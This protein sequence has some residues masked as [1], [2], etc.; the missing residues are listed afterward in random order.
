[1]MKYLYFIILLAFFACNRGHNLDNLIDAN[2]I[3]QDILILASDSLEGRAPMTVGEQRTLAYLTH[4]MKEIGLEPAFGDSYLQEVPLA[5]ITSMV[6]D[7]IVISSGK[8]NLELI[9]GEN[10]T[11]WSPLLNSNFALRNSELIFAGFGIVAPEYG[12][13]DFDGIDLAGKTVVVLVNDPG[14]HTGNNDLFNANAMTFYGRWPYKFDAANLSGAAGCIIIHEDKAAGYPWSVVDRSGNNTEYYLNNESLR[15][16]TCGVNGWITRETAT[17]LFE[18]CGMDYEQMKSRATEPGFK[19]VTMNAN[20]SVS[21]ENSWKESLSYNVGGIIRGSQLPDEALV[22]TAHWDHLGKGVPIDGDSIYN[23]ASDNAAAIAWMLSIAK[24]F[25]LLEKAPQ[26]SILFL[27]PTAE[28]SGLIGSNH[29]VNNSIFEHSKT[30]ACFN[31]DVILF[32]GKFLDVTVTGLGHSELDRYLEEE[33]AKQ[34]RYICNDPNPENGM[35]FRSDQ[36]PFL[37]AGIPALFAKGYTHQVDMG[38]EETLKAVEE[39]WRV[40]YHK[41]SDHYVPQKHNLDG[42][43]G[44]TKLFFRLGNRLANENYFPKWSKTSEFYVE[45]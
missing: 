2:Q 19:P 17:Q 33:A 11:L 37:R 29:Y 13:N 22:Y 9:E 24:G 31:S 6:Q 16:N 44:D 39:Y 8:K 1:M 34:G 7:R 12:W 23:G 38:K 41:P 10:Y 20:Y 36:L 32:L 15:Q 18:L 43:V 42:L 3:E 28:E 5:E 35:F 30:V 25:K 4:R 45:R 26:R 21:I 27:S 40:T 14:F